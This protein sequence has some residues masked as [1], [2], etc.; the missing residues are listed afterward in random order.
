MKKFAIEIKWGFIFTAAAILWIVFE[1]SMGWHSELIGKHY[2]YTNFFGIV[3]VLIYFLAL[4][5]KRKNFYAEGMSWSQGFVSGIILT[6]VITILSPLSQYITSVFISPEY[7]ENIIEYTVASG[8]MAREDAEAY[9]NLSS[10][11]LLNT[12]S[13]LGMGI[14]TSAIVALFLRKK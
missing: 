14:V 1:K 3:A 8:R 10:Y 4:L 5:D 13:A 2:L 12:F 9:F 11:I 6:V 7:F